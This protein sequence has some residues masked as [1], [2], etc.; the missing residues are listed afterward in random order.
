MSPIIVPPR[1]ARRFF[2]TL[3]LVLVCFCATAASLRASIAA[4]GVNSTTALAY[5]GDASST[6]LINLGRPTLASAVMTPSSPGFPGG[7]INDGGYGNT[8]SNNTYFQSD[9]HFPATATF[10][11]N[12]TFASN[13][14]DITSID[15]FMGWF[16][17]AQAQANQDY[18]VEVRTVGSAGFRPLAQ[19]KYTP[20][21]GSGG[22]YET[23]V[24]V[25]NTASGVLATNVEAIRF[26]FADPGNNG[27]V[28]REIDVQGTPSATAPPATMVQSVTTFSETDNAYA[29]EVL[30]NDL[31]NSGQSTLASF[32]SS[33]VPSLGAGGQ[34]DGTY[35]LA[36]TTGASWYQPAQLPATLTFELNTSSAPGGYAISAIRTFAGWKDGETQ[37]CANQKYSI[38]Y[39]SVGS[40]TWMPLETVDYSPF[41]TLSNTPA[42]TRVVVSA[43]TGNLI[44]HVTA[45]RFSFQVP[46]R[47]NGTAYGTVLQEIDVVGSAD[48]S[49]YF[50]WAA[51]EGLNGSNGGKGQDADDDGHNN[52]M[53]HAFGTDPLSGASGALAY[54]DGVLIARGQPIP[55]IAHLENGVEYRAVF[56]RRK[57]HVAAGLTYTVQF[58]VDL[59]EWVDGT[60]TPTVVA[61]DSEIDAVSVS[62][63][64][65]IP[66]VNGMEQPT[67]FRVSVSDI[68]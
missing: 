22:D 13:G 47:S 34:N 35:G 49:P 4:N 64:S 8:A 15:S 5:S 25:S 48:L 1:C 58:S 40:S 62:Y 57:D 68:P 55:R 3:A 67:F 14:Y 61:S 56:C 16:S 44:T 59:S 6:D 10:M 7:G 60:D 50:S 9:V 12:L 39:R 26:I 54:A 19:V 36:S 43:P 23:R 21:S 51:S 37:T 41:S 30:A 53:E 24:T 27:T 42:S 33:T 63:P 66:T 31:V 65:L 46:T 29:G 38:E 52:L 45:L 11:L 32:S 2:E 20:F 18:T 17:V 28:I